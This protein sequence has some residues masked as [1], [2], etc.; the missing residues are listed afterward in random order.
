ME[1]PDLNQFPLTPGVYLYKDEHGKIIY[2]GKAVKLRNRLASY[3]RPDSALTPKTRVMLQHARTIDILQTTTEKEALLLEASLI[4]KHRPRYNICLRDDKEYIVFR[5]QTKAPFP[6]LEIIRK[7]SLKGDKK[8]QYQGKFCGPFSS[9]LA[10]KETWRL[11]HRTFPLRRC[12]DRA[13]ANRTRTCLYH[14]MG[15]CLGP[16]VEPVS[17]KEYA[18][19]LHKVDLL[20]SGRST[21]LIQ[22]L[23]QDM[24][25]AAEDLAFEQAA[26]LRDQ[27]A[28]VKRTVERQSVVL[29]HRTNIDVI[30][31]AEA[32]EG[33]ALGV[34]F[35]REGLLLDGRNFFWPGL[36]L[37]E[38]PELLETFLTQ[39]YLTG[40]ITPPAK[41]ILPWLPEYSTQAQDESEN[42]SKGLL[43][44]ALAEIG[45]TSVTIT[46]PATA[47]EDRL[48]ILAAENAKEAA[49]KLET[50]PMPELLQRALKAPTPIYRIEA[51]DISHTGGTNTRAGMVVFENGQPTK[52]DYRQYAL[53]EDLAEA[54]YASGDD[55]AALSLWAKRRATAGAP[56]PD[57]ILIDGG[58][59]QLA[60]VERV[61]QQMGLGET[62]YLAAIT[63]ARDEEGM[64]DRRAGNVSDRIFLPSRSNPLPLKPGSS[65]LL[66]LQRVRDAVH[67]YAL[68]RH[69]QARS[70]AALTGELT[71]LPGIGPKTAKLLYEHF[72]SLAAMTAA[73]AE[74]LQKVPGIGSQKATMLAQRLQSLL[75]ND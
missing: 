31:V 18:A 33:L 8:N 75:S 26:R 55:Y 54:G 45:Q 13:F 37:E 61:F 68:G 20:L 16:C 15:Q 27:I 2:V 10:A 11:I 12:R 66:Y 23:E 6:R 53:D 3:F 22:Q 4:K 70:K 71:R 60:A 62:V 38:T 58:K 59:E 63:K 41:I 17:Q 40:K 19:M 29:S 9:A 21:E 34:L 46:T 25:H 50:L 1:K 67:D 30:G 5:I 48:A 64:A 44:A 74:G 72:G 52:N 47:D 14:H 73:G 35:V 56:W 65:E 24:H 7:S 43:E 32:N 42:T 69:R 57:L 49:K 28:A 51:V 36:S 39:F